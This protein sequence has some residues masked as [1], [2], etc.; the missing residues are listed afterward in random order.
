MPIR[1]CDPCEIA[2]EY[3]VGYYRHNLSLVKTKFQH[4]PGIVQLIM[5]REKMSLIANK[6]SLDN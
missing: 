6:K 1:L 2:K 3:S 5:C 4:S